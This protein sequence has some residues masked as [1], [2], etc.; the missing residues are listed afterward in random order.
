MSFYV[1][2]FSQAED[3]PSLNALCDELL[4]AGYE[5]STSPGKEEP[6]FKEQN[7]SSF[8]FQYNEKNKPIFVERNTIKDEDSLFKEEQKEFLDDVKALPYSKGQKK[9]VEVLKNTE[10]IYAFELDE[11]IT[12]EGWE[13]LE[14]LLDFLCDATDGYVQ[15]DEEGIYDQE[16]NLLVEID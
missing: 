1:R 13:F 7:W 12:E 6:E 16:G 3:Y 4:E 14:C 11:D 8:V 9:A 5:F 2:V 15:V 10:Q